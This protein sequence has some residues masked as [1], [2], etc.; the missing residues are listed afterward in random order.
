MYLEFLIFL[1]MILIS[2]LATTLVQV[3]RFL[4]SI[5]QRRLATASFHCGAYARSLLHWEKHL[6]AAAA[7]KQGDGE[8]Q[9]SL[10]TLQLV[11]GALQEQGGWKFNRIFLCQKM[12]PKS[13]QKLVQSDI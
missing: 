8:L 13:A 12:A 7:A 6:T 2:D 3:E 4:G 11:C 9:E 1:A 5:S 10:F